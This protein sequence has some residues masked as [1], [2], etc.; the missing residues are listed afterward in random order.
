MDRAFLQPQLSIHALS[1]WINW[2]H[3]SLVSRK[4][5]TKA[6]HHFLS[7]EASGLFHICHHLKIIEL[8]SRTWCHP[9]LGSCYASPIGHSLAQLQ[10][11]SRTVHQTPNG[12]SRTGNAGSWEGNLKQKSGRG[13]VC[14]TLPSLVFP[15]KTL[16]SNYN[17]HARTHK[18]THK[19]TQLLSI[20]RCSSRFTLTPFQTRSV[21][22]PVFLIKRVPFLKELVRRRLWNLQVLKWERRI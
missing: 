13:R 11:K 12:H 1:P 16:P 9:W 22:L 6:R 2:K 10:Y 18:Q 8:Y 15:L 19:H 20:P 4:T 3:I 14:L 5:K 7:K 17:M 21:D